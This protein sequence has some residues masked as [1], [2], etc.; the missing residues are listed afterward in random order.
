MFEELN[1]RLHGEYSSWGGEKD[2]D[3]VI[4]GATGFTGEFV[5]KEVWHTKAQIEKLLKRQLRWAIAG[6]SEEKLRQVLTRLKQQV[7]SSSS[8]SSTSEKSDT[9]NNWPHLLVADVASTA[10]LV[11]MA[12]RARVVATCVGPYRLYGIP[13]LKAC[14]EQQAHYVDITG[15]SAFILRSLETYNEQALANRVS[16]VHACGYDS[17]SRLH[18]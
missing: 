5:A 17:V 6:R 4:F 11:S 14:V 10:S 15:E 7:S 3:L 9:A 8:S 2:L 13:V 1:A 18:Q 16:I 12:K